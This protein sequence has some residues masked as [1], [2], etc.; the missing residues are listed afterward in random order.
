MNDFDRDP[1]LQAMADF[2]RAPVAPERMEQETLA[3]F[4]R[5]RRRRPMVRYALFAAAGLLILM[6]G[7]GAGMLIDREMR[8]A[9]VA[10]PGNEFVPVEQPRLVVISQGE[11]P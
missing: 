10:R 6:I 1:E 3:A 11:R 7:A 4:R 9:R 8:P 2:W 5:M